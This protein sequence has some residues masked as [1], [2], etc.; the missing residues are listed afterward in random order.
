[1]EFV[2]PSII[3]EFERE[4]IKSFSTESGKVKLDE[5]NNAKVNENAIVASAYLG[6]DEHIAKEL[7]KSEPATY[8]SNAAS[9][10][11]RKDFAEKV[12][13]SEIAENTV[14]S[15]TS[16]NHI[17]EV[18]KSDGGRVDLPLQNGNLLAFEAVKNDEGKMILR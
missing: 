13:V 4:G 9:E 2:N 16:I 5:F 14:L 15:E 12:R 6:S 1:M 17:A 8:I 3:S 7:S 10:S 11:E 18:V